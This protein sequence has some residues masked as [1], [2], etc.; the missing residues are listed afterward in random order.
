[1]LDEKIQFTFDLHKGRY[2]SPRI[3]DELRA[4]GETC[5]RHR[6]ARRMKALGMKAVAAKK[7]KVTT[8]ADHGHPSAPNLLAQDFTA[9]QP[10]QKWASDLTYIWTDEGWLYLTTVMD[11]FSRSIIGWSMHKRMT[12][13]LICDALTMA[14]WRRG[15]PQDVV[16]HSDRGSQYCSGKYQQLLKDNKLKCSMSGRGNCYDNAVMGSF[17]HTL[18]VEQ[19]HRE[20]YCTREQA[21]RSVFEYIEAYYNTI[22][23]HSANGNMS[24]IQYEMMAKAL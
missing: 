12:K 19:V 9:D 10:N 7:F 16:V 18:K 8:D 3:T 6:V 20:R 2:G 24:P 14:L 21:R 22:R 11:L 23:R 5:G 13:Q 17:F 15:F 1:M 4:K